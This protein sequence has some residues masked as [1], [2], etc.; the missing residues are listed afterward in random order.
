[1]LMESLRAFDVFSSVFCLDGKFAEA[2]PYGHGHINE[3]YSVS[4]V[5][6]C[7]ETIRVIMQKINFNVFKEPEKLMANIES[8]VSHLQKKIKAAGGDPMRETLNI[9]P[10]Y[11]GKSYCK[12]EEG[13][14]WRAYVFINNATTYQVVENP[15]HLYNAGTAFG[16]FQRLL[17]DF[18][19]S[20]LYETIPDFHNT[21]KRYNSFIKAVE[22]D[23]FNRA[24]S[25]KDEI[26]FVIDRA[27]DTGILLKLHEEGKIPLRVTHNDTKFNN[28][29]IDNDTGKAICV[30]DLDTVMPGLALYDFGDAIRSGTNPAEEDEKDLSKVCMDLGLFEQFSKGFLEGGENFLTQCEIDYMPFAA[31][32]MTL[33]C[34]MRFLT[35][36]LQGDTYFRIHRDGHNVDRTRTQFKMVA[37]ME[38]K[39]EEMNKIIKKYA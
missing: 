1:M 10:T 4:F 15:E 30:L 24:A 5:K 8:V 17:S 14:Y 2:I 12:T 13:D 16:K 23:K 18:P 3:T 38:E 28:V 21:A 11:E 26:K 6:E 36:Y 32:I 37:D 33:E 29:M 31:K 34:G 39:L 22:E 25:V 9:I 7:G 19:A 35:D 27:D 20:R